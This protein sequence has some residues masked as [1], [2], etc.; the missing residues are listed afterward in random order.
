M[1]TKIEFYPLNKS[2]EEI[3][4]YVTSVVKQHCLEAEWK[5]LEKVF[6][7]FYTPYQIERRRHDIQECLYESNLVVKLLNNIYVSA[8]MGGDESIAR[9]I[10]CNVSLRCDCY[11]HLTF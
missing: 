8:S 6:V 9:T 1:K 4:E 2:S 5:L 3:L 11:N 10:A 7:S